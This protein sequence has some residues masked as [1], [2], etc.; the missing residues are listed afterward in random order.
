MAQTYEP[1]CGRFGTPR[2]D[3]HCNCQRPGYREVTD[4]RAMEYHCEPEPTPPP[5]PP[6]P[7]PVRPRNGG[8]PPAVQ[9]AEP[10]SCPEG[11]VLVSR[12]T[13]TMGSPNG[14]G[15]ADEHPQ[16]TVTLRAFCMDRLEVTVAQY[17]ACPR[18]TCSAPDANSGSNYCNWG[19]TIATIIP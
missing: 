15:E 9:Q 10:T 4:R 18:G 14:T 11:M 1:N 2:A 5:P 17:A 19:A 7:P 8:R 3:G 6:P 16:H 13:F 12:G